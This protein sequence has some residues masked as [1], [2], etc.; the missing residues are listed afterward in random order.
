M[1]SR[2]L[3]EAE[4]LQKAKKQLRLESDNDLADAEILAR[5]T[6]VLLGETTLVLTEQVEC[7]IDIAEEVKIGS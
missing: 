6:N 5:H 1:R 4:A 2:I 7:I 3:T